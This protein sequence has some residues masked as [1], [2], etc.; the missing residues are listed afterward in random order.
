MKSSFNLVHNFTKKGTYR[1]KYRMVRS[2]YA[3]RLTF[4]PVGVNKLITTGFVT[5]FLVMCFFFFVIILM[6]IFCWPKSFC[7]FNFSYYRLFESAAFR[8]V[9]LLLQ[10]SRILFF[11]MRKNHG[12]IRFTAIVELTTS[13]CWINLHPIYIQ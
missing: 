7:R 4:F 1:S 6:V 12:L 3:E 9:F 5:V 8:Q 11:V 13:I 10:C 2:F